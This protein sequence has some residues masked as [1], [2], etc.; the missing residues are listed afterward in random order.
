MQYRIPLIP[1]FNQVLQQQAL[2][3][4]KFQPQIGV[5]THLQFCHI[6]MAMTANNVHIITLIHSWS[7]YHLCISKTNH[8]EKS[9]VPIPAKQMSWG[10][11]NHTQLLPL[12]P[13]HYYHHV[14]NGK[15][16]V[17]V[18][19]DRGGTESTI[20][21]SGFMPSD[22]WQVLQWLQKKRARNRPWRKRHKI[23]PSQNKKRQI[24]AGW[25]KCLLQWQK[26][27][28]WNKDKSW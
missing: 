2:K 23:F 26:Q 11:V 15:S 24:K 8:E 21:S 7:L 14:S 22:K 18:K 5:Y 9:G 17:H 20:M 4:A 25:L 28:S 12:H 27:S 1:S 6:Y 19:K 10:D 16:N 3:I 13:Y